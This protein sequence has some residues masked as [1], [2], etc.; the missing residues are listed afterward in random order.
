MREF[1]TNQLDYIFF[2]YGLAFL[3][4]AVISLALNRIDRGRLPW[5]WLSLYGLIHGINEWLDMIALS[6]GNHPIFLVIRLTVLASS[7]ACLIEF[8]RQ[9]YNAL[10]GSNTPAITTVTLMILS[11]WGLFLSP[12]SLFISLRYTLALPAAIFSACVILQFQ[13]RYYPH[14]VPLQ[15]A[16]LSLFFLALTSGLIV[17]KAS[18]YPAALINQEIFRELTGIPIQLLRGAIAF[19]L[20][21]SIWYFYLYLRNALRV[22]YIHKEIDSGRWLIFILSLII[23]IGWV[24]TNFAERQKQYDLKEGLLHRVQL[25]AATLDLQDVKKLQWSD[26]DLSS[27]AYQELKQ[28]MIMLQK[29]APDSRFVCLMGY[30]DHKTYILVDSEPPDSPDYS[31]PGQYY[32]EASKE[33]IRLLSTKNHELIGPLYDRWGAWITGVSTVALFDKKIVHLVFDFDAVSWSHAINLARMAPIFITLMMTILILTFFIMY[34]HS[35]D[36]REALSASE[37]TLRRVF[38]HVYDAIIVHDS[39]GRIIDVNDRTL[40]LYEI[41]K[42]EIPFIT[43]L[44]DLTAPG[45]AVDKLYEIWQRVLAGENVLFEWKARRPHTDTEF[46]V[47]LHLSRMD[48]AGKPVIVATVRDL[49]ENKRAEEERSTLQEQ[50]LQ[51]QKM[52][53]VG[54]L[55]GG[56]AHDFNNMLAAI[57]GYTELTLDYMTPPGAQHRECLLEIQK[58]GERAKSLTRQLLAFGRKQVLEFKAI[59]LN[60][61][62][63]DFEKLLKRLIGEDI[64]INTHLS[65]ALPL[66]MADISQIEQILLNLAINARDAMPRGGLLTIDTGSVILNDAY[67]KTRPTM[68]PGEYVILTVTDTGIGMDDETRMRIFEPFFTTKEKAKGTGLG[69]STVYGI[70]SQHGGYIDVSSTIGKGSTFQILFPTSAEQE[71]IV[72]TVAELPREPMAKPLTIL[73]VEDDPAIRIL[74][75]RFLDQMG[76]KVLEALDVRDA[77][78]ICTEYRNKIDLLLTDVVMPEMTGRQLYDHVRDFSPDMRV[79][80]MSGYPAEIIAHHG[81]LDPGTLFL[82]KP[83]S[84]S[85]LDRFLREAFTPQ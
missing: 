82:Q 9:G 63:R 70:V 3:L 49:T 78:R 33:Y 27:T 43:I 39:E 64:Q 57:L 53:S 17:P 80:Y 19:M 76:H 1:F 74:T 26:A 21:A 22:S 16:A 34:Q 44:G 25:A 23:I 71:E 75:C 20:T 67:V 58:A 29:A 79:I 40:S 61:V 81:V 38:D 50:L 15:V 5:M 13:R 54:R 18:F 84:S 83:F 51:S 7:F 73:V 56:V 85:D 31:P 62:I 37:I 6:F 52:E 32:A 72:E 36:I 24:F 68:K 47:E 2:C 28:Q 66:I 8:S 11:G 30:R 14:N 48:L 42:N 35:L 10:K 59:D 4:L 69:L 60:Q 12:D 46:P 77:I 41:D 55:A 65:P 45:I